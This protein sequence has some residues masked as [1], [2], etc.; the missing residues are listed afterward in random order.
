MRFG[1]GI[2]DF[3]LLREKGYGYV[4]KTRHIVD[5]MDAAPRAFLSRPRRFGK[6]LTISTIKELYAGK[7]ALFEGLW[8]YD[9]WD[10]E[11]RARPVIWL[12]F[13]GGG[14]GTGVAEATIRRVIADA[15][16]DLAIELTETD[17]AASLAELITAA[18]S[19]SPAGRVVVLVDEYDKPVVDHLD[20]LDIAEQNIMFL[21]EVY[22][23]FKAYDH[24]LEYLLLT[25]VSALSK[26][27]VFSGLNNLQDMTLAPAAR[28]LV[29]ITEA[30]IDEHYGALIAERGFDRGLMREWYNGYSWG[31]DRLYNPWSL[32]NFLNS[33]QFFNHWASTGSPRWLVLQMRDAMSIPRTP[34]YADQQE[35][36]NL[37]IGRLSVV[38]LLFQ[39][40]YL[41]IVG[42][43][44]YD[45]ELDYPN[46]E[47]RQTIEA[48]FLSSLIDEG[49]PTELR[50]RIRRAILRPDQ[51]DIPTV[52]QSLN[53]LFAEVPYHL[54]G[55][56]G[57]ETERIFHLVVYLVF[58]LTGIH[59]RAEVATARGRA[60]AVVE[61]DTHVVGFEFKL[62]GSA[63]EALAQV[64]DRDYLRPH[65]GGAKGV[66][67]VGANFSSAA[68]QIDE[69]EVATL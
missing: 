24:L 61:T 35:L 40:G 11:K 17:N 20:D 2:Q 47:V 56:E 5:F 7:R 62:D 52:V 21:R 45:F 59:V 9:N 14:F 37:T 8:A 48:A 15:A 42:Q 22:S 41:T 31:G 1:I 55:P 38:P 10:F 3:E 28:T 29:G 63:A 27:S 67:A 30:E 54:W 16:A 33:G 53:A 13:G 60:D 46:R 68:R 26:V 6:S 66:L 36:T 51:P 23:V 18:A 69:Y 25:G 50:N 12:K 39:T 4:D 65:V 32:T 44:D 19:A 43:T 34:A 49:S 64:G 57:S 58:R